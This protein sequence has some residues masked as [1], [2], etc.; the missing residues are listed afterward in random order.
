[1]KYRIIDIHPDDGFY[2]TKK[3][4]IGATGKFSE[5]GTHWGGFVSGIFYFDIP[6]R[7]YEKIYEKIYFL[8]VFLAVVDEIKIDLPSEL[9]EI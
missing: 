5:F 1:M 9:F 2:I 6:V 7:V 4:F 3:K 8:R